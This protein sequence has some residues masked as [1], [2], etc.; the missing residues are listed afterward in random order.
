[1]YD[2]F[3]SSGGAERIL[4]VIAKIFPQADW[5]SSVVMKN[6]S[7]GLKITPSFIQKLP[8]VRSHRLLSLP[9]YPIAF[10]SFDFT[11]Y[12]LVLSITSSFAKGIIT[13][14]ETPH[15]CYLLTPT[16]F[17]WS[18][19]NEYLSP[20]A[21]KI[22]KPLIEHLKKWDYIAAQRPDHFIAISET[23]SN[24]IKN[25]YNKPSSIVYPPF[26]I[27]HWEH[28]LRHTS[29]PSTP[30]ADGYYLIVSRLQ[31]YKKVDLAV[32]AFNKMP[33]RQLVI[34]GNGPQKH[35]LESI[36]K[37]NVHFVEAHTDAQLAF[38]YGHAKAFIMPHIEDF[39][40]TS[41]EAQICSCPVIAYN[42]G[43]ATETV[44]HLKTGF[45]YNDQSSHGIIKAVE[46]FEEVAPTIDHYL[47][48]HGSDA[49]KQFSESRFIDEFTNDIQKHI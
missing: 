44:R 17:L 15:I 47:Q 38:L 1:M 20:T 46:S 9:L 41:L 37:N 26:A 11:G 10:E 23:V 31:K 40:Y 28:H 43:G 30:L 14:P 29:P 2:W 13:R 4:P 32:R 21:K 6:K 12:D 16:R 8:V 5:Y 19:E 24:R 25:M 22:F 42:D 27:K 39:G 49:V 36:A 7:L 18:A 3:D 35:H 33:Q 34:V 48:A 45:L